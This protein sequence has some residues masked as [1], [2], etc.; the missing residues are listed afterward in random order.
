MGVNK[1]L[2]IAEAVSMLRR[3]LLVFALI[4]V[5]GTVISFFY[6]LDLPKLY[7]TSAVIQIQTSAVS[8]S[9]VSGRD[10]SR[11]LQQLQRTEQ[12][13]MARDHL[14]RI[15]SKYNLFSDI[16]GASINDK[17]YW[18]RISTQIE[19]VTNPSL[20]W[21]TDISPT[22]LTITVQ[23]GDPVQVADVANEF[24]TSV[25]E[26]SRQQ[27]EDR[28]REALEFFES[29]ETRVGREITALD[30]EIAAFKRA[31][32]DAL[33]DAIA[34]MRS[35]LIGLEEADLAFEQQLVEL[36]GGDVTDR[37]PVIV[38]RINEIEEQRAS[39][40]ERRDFIRE[41]ISRAPQV[42]KT[43]NTLTRRLDK[44][45][46]QYTIITRHRAEAEMGQMLETNRQSE[47]FEIL[48]LAQIPDQPIAPSRRK[49]FAMGSF[50]SIAL[51]SALVYVL[52]AL[53]PVLRT[54]AQM[55]RQLGLRPVVAIPNIETTS[56]MTRRWLIKA[57]VA[58]LL[59]LAV[60]MLLML[61]GDYLP[62][63]RITELTRA[64]LSKVTN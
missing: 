24:V 48:E 41:V 9:L 20:Q 10:S 39:L 11:A 57:A 30:T 49:V 21:R 26:Q 47:N 4:A 22:A 37:R 3:R 2:P 53:N 1:I 25:L 32:A 45:E 29:E 5:T 43:F 19:Q 42:E 18:L 54:A 60:P 31:N 27:R 15:I 33:P 51:A 52:E 63:A 28:V 46:E 36:T 40:G 62:L 6:A 14:I 8:D 23:L 34:A 58:G 44:L 38:K 17:V 64:G 61:L 56:D 7:A 59:L 50:A 55:E 16:P 12:R 35:Q 13:L